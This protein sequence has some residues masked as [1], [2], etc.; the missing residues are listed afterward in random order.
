[1]VRSILFPKP[2]NFK[3]YL[4]AIKFVLLLS[5]VG[6]C[7]CGEVCMWGGVHVRCACGE[8]SMCG[9]VH[10]LR[11]ACVEVYMWEVCMC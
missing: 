1:M 11:C 8:V 7:T 4:D 10:V 3:F 2:F 5:I 6:K 9:G